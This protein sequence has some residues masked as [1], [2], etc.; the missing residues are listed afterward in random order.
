MG[1]KAKLTVDAGVGRGREY[2]LEEGKPFYVG[3]DRKCD[4]YIPS[5]RASRVHCKIEGSNGSFGVFDLD[6]R[7]GTLVNEEK[8]ASRVL[9]PGDTI[10]VAG[11]KLRF[12]LGE[13]APSQ[14]VRM[15]GTIG[16]KR[17]GGAAPDKPVVAAPRPKRKPAQD[18]SDFVSELGAFQFTEEE[19]SLAGRALG[20]LKLL[21]LVGKGQRCVTYKASDAAKNRLVAVKMLRSELASEPEL[22]NWLAAGAKRSGE[23]GHEN[24]V[25]VLRG[26][27]EGELLYVVVQ[28][29][30]RSAF[31]R[32]RDAS[33]GGLSG[34]KSALQ[35]LVNVS[36]ALEFGL[37]EHGELHGGVR[38]SK[39][40]YDDKRQAR[41]AGLGFANGLG[42]PGVRGGDKLHAYMAPELVRKK[43]EP[44]VRADLYSLGACFYY[45]VT[46]RSPVR[47]ARGA[48]P[49]PRKAHSAVPESLV[50]IFERMVAP[51]PE[52]RY[53]SYSQLLHDLRWALRGE[54]WHRA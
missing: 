25:R 41:L 6:S 29:M 49:S 53:E 31:D 46:G 38:P 43:G 10:S 36:R 22:R 32:F 5:G 50:R 34:V 44:G 30:E 2:E 40:L 15:G 37:R 27:R 12:Q 17:G 26:G 42:A 19:K 4:Y 7:N 33:K 3:R 54:A 16:T 24:A 13:V 45:M 35:T 52:E 51:D 48:I 20:G 18:S 1:S 21:S 39:I 9:R 8:V 28:Y 47:D 11:N 23:L 14:L